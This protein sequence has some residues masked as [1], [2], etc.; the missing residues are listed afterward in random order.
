MDRQT[1]R[2]TD[3]NI[4][5]HTHTDLHMHEWLCCCAVAK[6]CLTLCDPTG[7]NTP[8]FPGSVHMHLAPGSRAEVPRSHDPETWSWCPGQKLSWSP[9]ADSDDVNGGRMWCQHRRCSCSPWGVDVVPQL[10]CSQNLPSLKFHLW[11]EIVSMPHNKE[12]LKT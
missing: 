4:H 8:G 2:Q 5:T 7:C 10:I 12:T 6:L 11:L 1:D 3:L 9:S